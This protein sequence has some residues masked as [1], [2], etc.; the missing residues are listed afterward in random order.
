MTLAEHLAEARRRFL[1]SGAA[2][3]VLG[4]VAFIVYPEIL[5]FL[6]GPYCRAT[7]RHCSFLV[8]NPLDGLNL[9]VQIAL[10]GGV[11]FASPLI[12]W[13]VWRFITPGLK[14]KERRYAIPF[15][16]ATVLFFAGGV[17]V[18]YYSFDNAIAWLQSIGGH[19]LVSYYN[20]N[21]YLSLFLLM[22]FIFGV[23]FEFP[24]VLVALELARLVTPAQLL[25]TWR[26]A[27][28]VITIFAAIFTP[29]GDPLSMLALGIPLTLFYFL[30]IGVGRL[31]RR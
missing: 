24:V 20:P 7:P 9:R 29:S 31:L 27:L 15:V 23:A 11:L 2:V 10:F 5:R 19:S 14:A 13:H 3:I 30:A 22:M 16:T 26:Y 25:R 6:Q 21:Q 12:L 8:T 18:A 28:I 4:I 1:Q 17:I